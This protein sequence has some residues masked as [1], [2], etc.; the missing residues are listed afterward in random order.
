MQ[1]NYGEQKRNESTRLHEFSSSFCRFGGL[2]P[3]IPLRAKLTKRR[4]LR[5][6]KLKITAYADS[7]S[8]SG[9]V[10]RRSASNSRR[11]YQESQAQGPAAPVKEIASFIFPAGAFVVVTFGM[12][13]LLLFICFCCDDSLLVCNFLF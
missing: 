6:R 3:L 9:G 11:V 12:P 7:S 2:F 4:C 5:L 10:R 13:F 8:S 1:I